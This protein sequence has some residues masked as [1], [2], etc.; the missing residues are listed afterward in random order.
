MENI[1]IDSCD[2]LQ[3]ITLPTALI[4]LSVQ[5]CTYLQTVVG[6]SD[7]IKLTELIIMKCPQLEELPVLSGV[8]CMEKI[9]IDSCEKLQNIMLPTM[10]ISLSIG[11]CRDL[12]RVVMSGD[13]TKLTKLIV[14]E[15]PEL[16][17]L[18]VLSGVSCMEIVSCEKL[19]NIT[20]PQALISLSVHRCRDL[21]RVVGYSDLTKL[22]E[23]IISDCPKLE[24]LGCIDFIKPTEL[25]ISDCP[26]LEESPSLSGLSCMKTI[27]ID[28][29]EKLEKISGIEELYPFGHCSN[30]LIRNCIHELKSVPFWGM[31][32]I[33]R[34]VNGAESSLN[35]DLFRDAN[36]EIG[37][38]QTYPAV[39]GCYVVGVD[40]STSAEEINESFQFSHGIW[41]RVREG[42]WMITMVRYNIN[43]ENVEHVLGNKG[44]IKKGF[45]VEVKESEEWKSLIALRT[46]VDRLY[47]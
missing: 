30:A 19:L 28:C 18:P 16:E 23:L 37:T 32:M 42:E 3:N 44:V 17:E 21:Q 47:Q 12:Q 1:E 22:T 13:L 9:E 40:S 7:L 6:S 2:K 29:C 10:L 46:I 4:T 38:P 27:E 26:E 5:R 8:S 31:V 33:G 11:C 15:C 41:P 14:T 34:V 25:I 35:E 36:I 39:I 45:R 43:F 20:L 24:E